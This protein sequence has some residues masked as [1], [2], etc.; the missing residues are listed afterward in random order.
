[1]RR[2]LRERVAAHASRGYRSIAVATAGAEPLELSQLQQQKQKDSPPKIASGAPALQQNQSLQPHYTPKPPAQPEHS[3]DHKDA[4]IRGSFRLTS[5]CQMLGLVALID[6]PR[7][8]TKRVI[9][10]LRGLGVRVLMLTGVSSHLLLSVGLSIRDSHSPC[11][12]VSFC[13][14][15]LLLPKRSQTRSSIA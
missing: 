10:Q 1:V 9:Q 14:M 12:V 5:R 3:Q 7:K 8:D 15:R 13:R 11:C 6:P 2:R 4:D